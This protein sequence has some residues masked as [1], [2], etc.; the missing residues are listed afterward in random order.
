MQCE[1]NKMNSLFC[2]VG[3]VCLFCGTLSSTSK[4][5]I[6]LYHFLCCILNCTF[7]GSYVVPRHFTTNSDYLEA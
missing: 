7:T 5:V 6:P 2:S 3:F 1:R 4:S